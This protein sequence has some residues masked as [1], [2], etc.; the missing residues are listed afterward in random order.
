MAFMVGDAFGLQLPKR[1]YVPDSIAPSSD[2]YAITGR[3]ASII[4][5]RWLHNIVQYNPSI[6]IEDEHSVEQINKLETYIQARMTNDDVYLAWMPKGDTKDVLFLVVSAVDT[7]EQSMIVKMLV[8][9]PYWHMGQI[10][11]LELKKAL[12]H[13]A[14]EINTELRLDELY[15]KDPRYKFEWGNW[16]FDN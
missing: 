15:N 16:Y 8:Q 5:M 13:L 6:S 3:Q 14:C 10:K 11:S 12:E 4:S 9:S 2:L 7:D 1:N